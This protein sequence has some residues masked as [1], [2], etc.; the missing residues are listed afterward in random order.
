MLLETYSTLS[1]QELRERLPKFLNLDEEVCK[2]RLQCLVVYGHVSVFKEVLTLRKRA[3]A[4][5]TVFL[6]YSETT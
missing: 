5:E 4:P 2:C 6:V 1:P 3:I